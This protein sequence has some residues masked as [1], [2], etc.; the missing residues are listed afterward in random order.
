MTGSEWQSMLKSN[1]DFG[2]QYTKTANNQALETA[3]M[4]ARAFGKVI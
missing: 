3:T 1:P 2:W 4:I